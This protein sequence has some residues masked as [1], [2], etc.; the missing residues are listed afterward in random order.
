LPGNFCAY[1]SHW[2]YLDGYLIVFFV[3]EQLRETISGVSAKTAG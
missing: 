1:T 2:C 3:A